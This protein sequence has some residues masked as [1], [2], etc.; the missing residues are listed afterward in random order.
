MDMNLNK[1]RKKRSY[2]D[3][4]KESSNYNNNINQNSFRSFPLPKI[5]Y[6][7]NITPELEVNNIDNNIQLKK[8]VI[9][10]I[11]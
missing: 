7:N 5:V 9:Y 2:L 6:N 3:I 10:I 4:I 8:Q 1:Y 11:Q